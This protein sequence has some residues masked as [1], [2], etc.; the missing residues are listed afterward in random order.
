MLSTIM[1]G[2]A[3]EFRER[4]RESKIL[5][6]IYTEW[7]DADIYKTFY[8]LATSTSPDELIK[9]IEYELENISIAKKT[10]ERIK[11]VWIANEIKAIDHIERTQ[12]N[13]MDDIINYKEVIADRIECIRKMD[14]KKLNQMITKMDLSHRSVVKM[15]DKNN[16]E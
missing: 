11:K 5:T 13:L 6:D 14:V 9:E 10:F 16:K 12:S 3:S 4:V 7:E 15:L 2:S 8:I 1:F